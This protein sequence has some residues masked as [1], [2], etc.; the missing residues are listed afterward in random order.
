[1]ENDLIIKTQKH[2][3]S[4]GYFF[5]NLLGISSNFGFILSDFYSFKY[6]LP[7]LIALNF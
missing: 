1:M 7:A 2:E 3:E 5:F 4:S 6:V